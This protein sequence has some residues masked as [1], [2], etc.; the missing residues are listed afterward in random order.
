LWGGRAGVIIP[1]LLKL[2]GEAAFCVGAGGGVTM[3]NNSDDTRQAWVWSEYR[4]EQ[5]GGAPLEAIE[6]F[7]VAEIAP[8][9][10][11][12][13]SGGATGLIL[14]AFVL[15]ILGLLWFASGS[16]KPETAA[17]KSA[18]P[19]VSS[20]APPPSEPAPPPAVAAPPADPAP[21]ATPAPAPEKPAP[22]RQKRHR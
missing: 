15:T 7:E 13:Q 10:T 20:E 11:A 22:R 3:A 4:G 16:N 6:V 2:L 17:E 21:A 1:T 8:A 18:P 5:A 19:A 14:A 9:P 12:A